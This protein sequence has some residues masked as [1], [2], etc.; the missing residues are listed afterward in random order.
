MKDLLADRHN[1]LGRVSRYLEVS[2]R[3]LYR[4]R[5]IVLHGGSTCGV[6]LPATLRVSAPLVGA[7]LDRLSHAD[8]TSG[9]TPLA[10]ATRAEIALK[11]VEDDV[12]PDLCDLIE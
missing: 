11:L 8:L 7:A 1:V 9:I 4:C 12:G 10:L 2:L 6:A 5:N 3:R